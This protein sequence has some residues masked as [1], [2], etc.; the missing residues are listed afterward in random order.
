MTEED[1]K[2]LAEKMGLCWHE[3]VYVENDWPECKKCKVRRYHV[4]SIDFSSYGFFVVFEW[5]KRQ[6]WWDEFLDP[7]FN[8]IECMYSMMPVILIGPH[9]AEELVKFLRGREK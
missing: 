7:F 1:S 3:W 8:R 4:W 6:E 2:F 5:A 9:L